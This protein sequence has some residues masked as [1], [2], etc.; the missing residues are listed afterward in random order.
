MNIFIVNGQTGEY[1]DFRD[2]QVKAFA[3]KRKANA[4]AK[5]LN[6]I[7]SRFDRSASY[8]DR[9]K[10]RDE[11]IIMG[12]EYASIDYTGTKYGVSEL[13]LEQ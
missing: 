9:D 2:W 6:A 11:L 5:K 10:L 8:E 3:L 7:A 12:D 4:Y 13:E 1:E